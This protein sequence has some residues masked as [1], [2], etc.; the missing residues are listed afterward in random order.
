MPNIYFANGLEINVLVVRLE[1]G[2]ILFHTC[3]LPVLPVLRHDS[4]KVMEYSRLGGAWQ[5]VKV[6]NLLERASGHCYT[7]VIDCRERQHRC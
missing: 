5:P 1:V 6:Y 2:G 4:A 7:I 3:V